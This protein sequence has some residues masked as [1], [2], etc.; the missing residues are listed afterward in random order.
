MWK[1]LV[2]ATLLALSV[3]V[4]CAGASD[5]DAEPMK[6][7][8]V[9]AR[10]ML[11]VDENRLRQVLREDLGAYMKFPYSADEEADAAVIYIQKYDARL[12]PVLDAYLRDRSGQ[13]IEINGVSIKKIIV[14][15]WEDGKLN[16]WGAL[17]WMNSYVKDPNGGKKLDG[18]ISNPFTP[19]GE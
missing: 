16:F 1:Q 19:E 7:K 3:S 13:D 2:T 18:M 10:E 14:K 4:G 15:H 5:K 8:Q 11:K 17:R 9:E 6:S 12:Q